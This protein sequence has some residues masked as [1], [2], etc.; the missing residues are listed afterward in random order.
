MRAMPSRTP[1][2]AGLVV[3][4]VGL[5]ASAQDLTLTSW[6]GP[7][8]RSQMFAFVRPFEEATGKEVNVEF[9]NGGLDEVRRQVRSANVKWDVVD[10]LEEDLIQACEEGLLAPIEP[11]LL[12]PGADG[13]PPEED[14]IDN[15][16]RPCGV[17]TM[18]WATAIGYSPDAFAG[19]KPQTLADFFDVERFPGNRGLQ[20]DPRIIMEWALLADGVPADEVYD[21]LATP[22]GVDRALAVMGPI[23]PFLV[24]WEEGNDPIDMLNDGSVALTSIWGGE[25]TDAILRQG[26]DITPLWDGLVLKL[27]HFGVPAG[28]PNQ[29]TALEFI[30]FATTSKQLAEQVKHIYH[31]PARQSSMALIDEEIKAYLPTAPEHMQAAL[32]NDAEFWAEN[33]ARL[34]QRFEEWLEVPLQKGLSGA[35]R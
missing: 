31:S 27:D 6:S 14:F 7:Y 32:E 22:A 12:A 24:W 2:A 15:G 13:T 35:P 10:F 8:M 1:L 30:R 21:V 23:K 33:H 11:A 17:G 29:E 25:M 19:D 9:Y 28:S 16:L 20:R 34:Q 18:A 26:H 4:S 3:L 5:P